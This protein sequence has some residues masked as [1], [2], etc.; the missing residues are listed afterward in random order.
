MNRLKTAVGAYYFGGT[1]F[2]CDI[3]PETRGNRHIFS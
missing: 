2:N 3:L 1:K